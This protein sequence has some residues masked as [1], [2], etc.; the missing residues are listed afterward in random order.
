MVRDPPA[1]GAGA[2]S[3]R[4]ASG[5]PGSAGAAAA[6]TCAAGLPTSALA[7]PPGPVKWS[8]AFNR[9]ALELI[10]LTAT[11]PAAA[12][13]DRVVTAASDT[14]GNALHKIERAAIAAATPISYSPQVGWATCRRGEC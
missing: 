8:D 14:A 5:A 6:A 13:A 2:S 7:L 10:A 9:A 1:V 11:T 12:R 3:R 4:A